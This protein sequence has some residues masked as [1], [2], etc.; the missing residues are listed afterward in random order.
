MA[1]QTTYSENIPVA[2][3]GMIANTEPSVLIS[4]T[5]ET[6]AGVAFGVPVRQGTG[7]NG[8]IVMGAGA[9]NIVGIT[10]RERSVNPDFPNGFQQYESARLM[11]KGVIWVT[12]TDA[13]GVV[14][15]DP[16]WVTEATGVFSNA[17]VG[18]GGGLRIN[19]ARWENT[20]ANGDLAKIR[21]DLD[22]GVTAGA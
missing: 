18:S 15:G 19:N 2:K 9:T 8:V 21:V 14:A 12:V 17:D 1:I 10:V 13:G 4:R 22:G 6:A 20:A 11:R 3:A 7:D 16:V 5:V